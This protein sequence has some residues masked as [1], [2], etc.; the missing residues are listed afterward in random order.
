MLTQLLINGRFVD[1]EG[2]AETILDPA[3]GDSIASVP[4]ASQVQIESAV[5]AAD[6]AFP[7]WART[8]PQ[9]RSLKLLQ[10][11]DAIEK[12]A[13]ALAA[14]RAGPSPRT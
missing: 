8:T 14:R 4:E 9:E 1:G 2:P 12:Q 5:A 6:A 13:E 11:A 10:V 7:A 3:S